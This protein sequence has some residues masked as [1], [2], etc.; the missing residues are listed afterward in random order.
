MGDVESV[1]FMLRESFG[2]ESEPRGNV[3]ALRSAKRYRY[4]GAGHVDLGYR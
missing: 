3:I 4:V 1:R 2:M